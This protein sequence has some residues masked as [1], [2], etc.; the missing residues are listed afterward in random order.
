MTDRALLTASQSVYLKV[1]VDQQLTL[2][3]IA[4]NLGTTTRSAQDG[5]ILICEQNCMGKA[6]VDLGNTQVQPGQQAL[7][8]VYV[9]A[10]HSIGTY[11]MLWVLKH[12]DIPCGPVLPI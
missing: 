5:Y 2:M 6:N 12:H 4:R 1:V 3:I 7:F 11:Q 9:N 8:P 10:P